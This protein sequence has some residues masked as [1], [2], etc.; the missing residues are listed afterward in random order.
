M[1]IEARLLS[2]TTQDP[3]PRKFDNFSLS[4]G[5]VQKVSDWEFVGEEEGNGGTVKI[6]EST[7]IEISTGVIAVTHN[8]LSYEVEGS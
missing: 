4:D 2:Y 6:G 7:I 1:T 8:R 3:V 5:A